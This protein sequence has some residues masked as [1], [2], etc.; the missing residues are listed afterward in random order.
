MRMSRNFAKGQLWSVMMAR[1][2]AWGPHSKQEGSLGSPA[3]ESNC[4]LHTSREKQQ[5]PFI[6]AY[7][8]PGIQHLLEKKKW[9]NECVKG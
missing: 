4:P 5:L 2:R 9:M 3:P 6:G 7:Y 1:V 8:M